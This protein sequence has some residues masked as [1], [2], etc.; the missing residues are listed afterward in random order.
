[1]L[2]PPTSIG[3]PG[4][5]VRS[6]SDQLLRLE[7]V[8]ED[9]DAEALLADV[10]LGHVVGVVMGEQQV[11]ARSARAARSPRAAAPTARRSR[12]RR[13][14]R[15]ARRRRGRRSTASRR[16]WSVRRSSRGPKPSIRAVDRRFALEFPV[17]ERLAYLNA[18]TE[19][20]RAARGPARPP[21]RRARATGRRGPR[22]AGSTSSG[23]IELRRA[24]CA[25]GSPP[26]SAATPVE[27]ALTGVHHRRR[28]RRAARRCDL[29]PGDEV[30]TTDEEHPGAARAAGR[31]RRRARASTS[32]WCRSTSWPARSARARSWW[33]ART[34]PG[35]PGE[36]V[37]AAALA[38]DRRAGAAR[39]RPGARRRARWTCASSAATSTPRRARSGCAGR[40]AAATSTCAR[41]RCG[42]ARRRRGRAT[43]RSRTRTTRSTRRFREGARRFDVGRSPPTTRWPGRWRR[44]TC[45]EDGRAS[46]RCTRAAPAWR[47][48]WPSML[49]E[50]GHEVAP[51]GRSTLV[52]WRA[53][54]GP[55]RRRAPGR[56]GLRGAQPARHPLVR[57]SVGAWTTR[58]SS[59]GWSRPLG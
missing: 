33:P 6:T 46:T 39:R 57:A 10:V 16:A 35:R 29:R 12:S 55:R 7:R 30:L 48:G 58:R 24:S 27:V 18:G 21:R 11:A 13:R 50:R 45:F 14:C 15:P 28:E 59:S 49:A 3:S 8:G 4:S 52:S 56:A 9:L 17:L 19:R 43:G 54:D 20:A 25:A 40:T 26:C 36:V 51:R 2:R 42:D 37:D 34:C 1:M 31:A 5:I 23:M 22:R 41:E 47:R 32:G 38:R 44:S 53:A